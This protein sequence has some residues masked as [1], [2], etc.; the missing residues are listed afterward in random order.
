M[1][2]GEHFDMSEKF[3]RNLRQTRKS[4]QIIAKPMEIMRD[5]NERIDRVDR[6]RSIG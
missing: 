3:V 6:R 4:I 1:S 2:T 5:L